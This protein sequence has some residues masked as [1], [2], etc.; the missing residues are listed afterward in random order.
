MFHSRLIMN[1][2]KAANQTLNF[3]IAKMC[4]QP[5]LWMDAHAVLCTVCVGVYGACTLQALVESR[6]RFEQKT[7]V[8]WLLT[9]SDRWSRIHIWYASGH[10]GN[11]LEKEK[12]A[13]GAL[14]GNLVPIIAG[15]KILFCCI[16]FCLRLCSSVVFQ[17]KPKSNSRHKCSAFS[18]K[19]LSTE[20][21]SWAFHHVSQLN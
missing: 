19:C 3:L 4:H 14:R 2:P 18:M 5:W 7:A 16:S 21:R 13:T 20:L 17:M 12:K 11:A 9:H 8:L 1:S 15:L 10:L 6:P